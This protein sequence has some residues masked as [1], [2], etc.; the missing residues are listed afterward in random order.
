M[1][2]LIELRTDC[3]IKQKRGLHFI[4]ASVVIWSAVLV[5]HLSRLPILT[6]NLLTFCC[7]APLMPLA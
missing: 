3:A 4:L 2:S 6:K 1:L 7:T 5:V